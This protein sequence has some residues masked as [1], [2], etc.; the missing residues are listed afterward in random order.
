M[1]GRRQKFRV[2]VAALFACLAMIQFFIALVSVWD[3]GPLSV[4]LGVF[5]LVCGLLMGTYFV[6]RRELGMIWWPIPIAIACAL[7]SELLL[8][9]A[10]VSLLMASL[11]AASAVDAYKWRDT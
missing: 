4:S 10:M 5:W 9:R 2:E 1:P 8:G 7:I 6:V 11:L 3:D